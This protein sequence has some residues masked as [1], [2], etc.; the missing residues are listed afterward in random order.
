MPEDRATLVPLDYENNRFEMSVL[1]VTEN[2]EELEGILYAPSSFFDMNAL[3]WTQ[4]GILPNGHKLEEPF[5][6]TLLRPAEAIIQWIGDSGANLHTFAPILAEKMVPIV[7]GEDPA[8]RAERVEE[9]RALLGAPR[10]LA[11]Q[12]Q[13]EYPT[14]LIIAQFAIDTRT[15]LIIYSPP[16]ETPAQKYRGSFT[17]ATLCKIMPNTPSEFGM[18]STVHFDIGPSVLGRAQFACDYI[19]RWIETLELATR[20]TPEKHLSLH[21]AKLVPRG[22]EIVVHP[23]ARAEQDLTFGLPPYGPQYP[24]LFMEGMAGPD[25]LQPC[26]VCVEVSGVWTLPPGAAEPGYFQPGATIV[27]CYMPVPAPP[28]Q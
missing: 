8:T 24:T 20:I 3:D 23:V 22:G 21:S 9:F 16:K 12:L 10:E 13:E 28:P 26:L 27:K 19:T 6:W 4:S 17:N 1:Y 18:T 14:G 2:W 5:P 15:L 25:P 7:E 11:V